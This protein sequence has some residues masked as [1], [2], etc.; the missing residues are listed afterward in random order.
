LGNLAGQPFIN[1]KGFLVGNGV[2]E[3]DSD[4]VYNSL[5]PFCFGH[6]L[7][8]I[9]TNE[10]IEACN[11][12]STPT[13]PSC[14][15]GMA[16]LTSSL[17]NVNRYQIYDDCYANKKMR[18]PWENLKWGEAIM[19]DIPCI[20]TEQAS[21]YFNLAGVKE[22]LHVIDVQWEICSDTLRYS[23]NLGSNSYQFYPELIDNYRIIIFSG[24]T[25]AAVPHVGSELWTRKLGLRV[26]DP[27]RQWRVN[28]QVAG[29]VVEY[30]NLSYVTYK[31]G[32]HTVP[33]SHPDE[34][35]YM[36]AQF[37]KNQPL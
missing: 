17:S 30:E 35:L 24:D 8:S 13:N 27:W 32:T 18:I 25:D 6:G 36:L 26:I 28:G 19:S 33:E 15:S 37:Y 20:N 3:P 14:V 16:E 9:D 23:K 31:G 7:I 11:G 4:S 10:K 29:Y 2:T 34:S 5:A 21:I 22:A 1:L 12:G